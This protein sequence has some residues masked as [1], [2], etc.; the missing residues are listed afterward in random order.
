M[1][2]TELPADRSAGTVLDRVRE[3]AMTDPTLRSALATD[4]VGTLRAEGIELPADLPVRVIELPLV[5][6]RTDT[7]LTV[8]AAGEQILVLP[9]LDE[10]A[11]LPEEALTGTQGG[12]LEVLGALAQTIH[13]GV[14]GVFGDP[15]RPGA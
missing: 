3:R 15:N 13:G 12:F 4:P 2:T 8:S 7:P 14:T 6:T 9:F 11:E 1:T 10:D 5:A